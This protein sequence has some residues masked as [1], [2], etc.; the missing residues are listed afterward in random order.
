MTLHHITGICRKCRRDMYEAMK[1]SNMLNIEFCCNDETSFPNFNVEVKPDVD[2]SNLIHRQSSTCSMII[3]AK[4][5]KNQAEEN[6]PADL[7]EYSEEE[8]ELSS[9]PLS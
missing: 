5:S 2:P 6:V 1:V 3:E 8:S 4:N 9:Q 7:Q